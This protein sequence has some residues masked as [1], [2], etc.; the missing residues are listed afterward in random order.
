MIARLCLPQVLSTRLCRQVSADLTSP[1]HRAIWLSMKV[2][3]RAHCE[4]AV[5]DSKQQHTVANASE[6]TLM[7]EA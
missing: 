6:G 1:T 5:A 4:D 3:Q 2:M 7:Q